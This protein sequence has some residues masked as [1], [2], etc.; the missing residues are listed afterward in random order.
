M[1]DKVAIT[2]TGLVSS[3][4]L[5]ASETWDALLSGKCGIRVIDDFD[6]QSFDCHAAAR[7]QGLSPSELDIHPRDSR[8]MDKHSFM[9]MKGSRDA[10]NQSKLDNGSITP[11]DIGYFA[12]MGMVDYDIEDLLPSVL[13]SL[14]QQGNLDYNKFFSQAYQ[15]IH[16]LW[17]LSMMNNISFCQVAIDLGIKGE[18]TVFSPHSDSGSHSIIEAH[19]YIMEKKARV[20]LAGGV[21]EKVSP[22]SLARASWFGILNNEEPACRPFG[23]ARKGT[24]LGE[25][26]GILS[27]ELQSSAE[28]RQI[29]CLAAISGYGASFEVSEE[30]NCPTSKAISLSMEQAISKA[31]LKP[32]D[33]DLIIAQGDGTYTG[34]KNEIE[35]M[36]LTFTDCIDKVNVFSSKGALSN[37]LAGAPAV[38]VIL[39]IYILENGIIP[40][41]YNSLPLEE[42]IKF[43]VISSEPLRAHPKRILINSRS[44]EGQCASLIIEAID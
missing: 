25:G 10:F 35:A 30:L 11:E 31:N 8:I 29:R 42:N 34:D 19:N 12:G 26:C 32:S 28:K 44:Y 13:K 37:L 21:S 33:I 43:N 4:G 3:L 27:L 24:I 7:V 2:G 9:L 22:S 41:T 5:N 20:V 38:D 1:S 15:D 18:N 39:G 40:A 16:P 17:P 36:Q 23:K 14:D 6:A